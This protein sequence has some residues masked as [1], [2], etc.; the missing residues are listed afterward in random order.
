MHVIEGILD[1]QSL[2]S[3]GIGQ[4][5]SL[6]SLRR[7]ANANNVET[8]S[9]TT[10]QASADATHGNGNNKN[11]IPTTQMPDILD[12]LKR[13]DKFDGF[14]TLVEGTG[15]AQILKQGKLEGTRTTQS[16]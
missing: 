16:S 3:S 9:S 14:V 12:T 5:G 11:A 4:P 2:W 7:P 15:L 6:A 10:L 8:S 1:W 13:C